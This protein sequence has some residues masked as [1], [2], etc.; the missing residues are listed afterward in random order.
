MNEGPPAARTGRP[1]GNREINRV[2]HALN[3]GDLAG[4]ARF[5]L[6]LTRSFPAY[7]KGWHLLGVARLGL[8]DRPGAVAA[9]REATALAAGDA[10]AWS[11]LAIALMQ[12]GDFAGAQEAFRRALALRPRQ[13]DWWADAALASLRAGDNG[14]AERLAREALRRAPAHAPALAHLAG[15]LLAENRIDEAIRVLGRLARLTPADPRVHFNLGSA[16]RRRGDLERAAGAYRDALALAPGDP[17]IL[18]PYAEL[19][20]LQGKSREGLE[21]LRQVLG[22][23]MATAD[24]CDAMGRAAFAAGAFEEAEQCY[25]LALDK[26]PEAARL[27]LRLAFARMRRPGH[28]DEGLEMLRAVARDEPGNAEAHAA[29]ALELTEKRRLYEEAEPHI[30]E[31]LRLK[32]DLPQALLARARVALARLD[33]DAALTDWRRACEIDPEGN[34]QGSL[35]FVANY[36]PDWPAE[37]IFDFYREFE[38]TFARPLYGEWPSSP[39]RGRAHRRL[40]IGYVS[41]D[42]RKHSARHFIAPLLAHHDHQAFEVFAYAE[43]AREDE[44]SERFKG[45]VDH[46]VP[47]VGMDHPE[48]AARIRD[49]EIDILVD[50]A[51]HTSGNRLAVFARRPAPVSVSWLGYG[52]TTGLTAIDWFL[53]DAVMAPRGCEHLFAE[54]VWRLPGCSL[55]YQAPEE[56]TGRDPGPLPAGKNG[57]VTFNSLSRSIRYNPRLIRVWARIL[58]RVPGSRLRLDS[59]SLQP[60]ITSDRIL[61]LFEREGIPAERLQVGSFG[62][63][64]DVLG[65]VDITLDCF[66][67]NSGTTLF[68]SLY[69]GVPFVTLK[70]RPSVGRLGAS[71]ATHVGHGE[72]IA[73]SED[74]YVEKAV[75]LAS[76]LD[77]LAAIRAGLREEME[78]SPLMDGPGFARRVEAAYREMWR[79]HCAAGG[80]E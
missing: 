52:Y 5:A 38:R 25:R 32:P 41:A 46:W 11:H 2:I 53:T 67:H 75:A 60:R 35:L 72:W 21:A 48:L 37:R 49:D 19:L 20:L 4:A 24:L 3:R 47:T 34:T 15:A 61:R 39:K 8:G 26:D 17:A 31:A 62:R 77:A 50:L 51:G 1:P 65:A 66:P 10:E 13:V 68:E 6:P 45:Y 78:R 16:L 7:A 80:K 74:E 36:H 54:G 27:R 59:P 79:I 63:V 14:E 18:V 56:L 30:G 42:F 9:L 28:E 22:H 57:Y 73:G 71:I 70:D 23:P 33:F 69:M 40:R 55:A 76:D 29:L 44:Y 64:A 58:H 12:G 43:V